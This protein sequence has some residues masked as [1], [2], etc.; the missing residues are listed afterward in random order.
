MPFGWCS[1]STAP[2]GAAR[3]P[4]RHSSSAIVSTCR[5]LSSP[6]RTAGSAARDPSAAAY[7]QLVAA[8]NFKQRTR[9]M[10][11]YYHADRLDYAVAGTPNHVEYDQGFFV[12]QGDGA[13]DLKPIAHLYKT[14]VYALAEYLDVPAGDPD[15][16]AH[17]GHVLAGADAGGVLLRACRTTADGP[18]P[19]GR[20]P[21]RPGRRGRGRRSGSPTEQV[22][23]VFRDIEAKRRA[24]RYLHRARPCRGRSRRPRPCAASLASSR[25]DGTP[26]P[27]ST[28]LV[29]HGRRAAPPRARTSSASYRDRRAGARPRPALDHRPRHRP[30]AD[31]Q[32]DGTTLDR[33]Q[34]RDLQL[35]GA[36][37]RAD[38]PR[39]PVPDAQRHRGDRPRLR[40]V[41][42]RAPSPLQRAVRRRALGRRRGDARAG[43]G[44]AGRPAA[45]PLRARRP[46]AGSP[47]R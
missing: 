33:L 30:A 14:Q 27:G 44:S 4:C 29:A 39:S 2:A 15:P 31:V 37:G 7:L 36:A 12:K 22:E 40:A 9:K 18:L 41:G 45:L 19:V 38:G 16:A 26:P 46:P 5:S 34:R 21:R 43:A 42:P 17:H 11:E 8:T 20:R 6:T 23:R 47:A 13:A 10:M 35:R 32:R 24:S 28:D 3:S 25:S 1:R